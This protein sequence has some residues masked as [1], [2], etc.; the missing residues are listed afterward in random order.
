MAT[1]DY[2]TDP[3]GPNAEADAVLLSN[4]LHQE[5]PRACQSILNRALAAVCPGGQVI[6]QGHFLNDDRISPTFTTLH[7]LSAFIL[8]EGGK[9]YTAKEM[10]DIAESVGLSDLG[11]QP[12]GKTRLTVIVGRRA[13]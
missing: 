8:W 2:M 3:F 10:I 1:V 11:S 5:S 13:E 6:I 9:S 7:S 12:V 4:V